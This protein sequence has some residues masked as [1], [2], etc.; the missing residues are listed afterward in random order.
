M[1]KEGRRALENE[2]ENSEINNAHKFVGHALN[3]TADS[4]HLLSWKFQSQ[5]LLAEADR[6]DYDKSRAP[7]PRIPPAHPPTTRTSRP[8]QK[9]NSPIPAHL[10]TASPK[11]RQYRNSAL[12]VNAS[13]GISS[14]LSPQWISQAPGL[15]A[16][17]TTWTNS[18]A[19]GKGKGKW[20]SL[21][22]L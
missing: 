13:D 12:H 2:E 3:A 17:W 19:K 1:D 20:N 9:I 7:A 10:R 16:N 11:A 8:N 22:K 18:V 14:L 6:N 15:S 21:D 5:N 4:D